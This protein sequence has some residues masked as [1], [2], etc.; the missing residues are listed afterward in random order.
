MTIF[1]ILIWNRCRC[2]LKSY[3]FS[4]F[5]DWGEKNVRSEKKGFQSLWEEVLAAS[6]Y[7]DEEG[8]WMGGLLLLFSFFEPVAEGETLS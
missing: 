1:R 3:L 5:W 4:V 7:G 8:D 6:S 2:K